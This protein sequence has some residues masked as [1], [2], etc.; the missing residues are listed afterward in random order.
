M[1]SRARMPLWRPYL[2]CLFVFAAPAIAL[3]QHKPGDIVIERGTVPDE[4]GKPVPYEIGTLYVPE[5]RSKPDSR[6]I[7]VGF[8]RI[9]SPQ[10]TGAPPVFWLPGGPG[11][12]VL[13]AFAKNDR[14]K[15]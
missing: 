14:G 5:N 4:Q 7:G 15:L 9:K 12:S 2:L 13:D 6:P 11:L 3:A 8:A 1:P 10:P